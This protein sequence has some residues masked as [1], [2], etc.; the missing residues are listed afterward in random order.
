FAYTQCFGGQDVFAGALGEH[1][2]T[3]QA[4]EDRDLCDTDREHDRG[5]AGADE[6][7]DGDGEQQ[8]GQSQHHGDEAHDH[9]V[10]RASPAAAEDGAGPGQAAEQG[11]E[12]EADEGGDHTDHE[13][14]AG[15][16][17]DA[18]EHVSTEVVEAEEVLRAWAD[19][20]VAV[21]E[22]F[23]APGLGGRAVGRDQWGAERDDHEREDDHRAGDGHGAVAH[24]VEGFSP[25]AAA[26]SVVGPV[27]HEFGEPVDLGSFPLV[28]GDV[29]WLLFLRC[30]RGFGGVVGAWCRRHHWART[31]GSRRLYEMSTRR[32][33]NT[34]MVAMSRMKPVR[35]G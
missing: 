22:D 23:I 24:P 19:E 10:D 28:Q 9:V 26:V 35:T 34:Y 18:G 6:R 7:G 29:P 3:Q 17:D 27:T 21:G 32:L 2:T 14:L 11:P 33:M 31:L 15:T 13:G 4:G 30:L 16:D 8:S 12:Q 20:L 25:D 1:G 5:E